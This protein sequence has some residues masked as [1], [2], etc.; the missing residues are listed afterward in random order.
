MNVPQSP[1]RKKLRTGLKSFIKNESRT[2]LSGRLVR[3]AILVPLPYGLCATGRDNRAQVGKSALKGG[4]A[5][6]VIAVQVR[7]DQ[8]V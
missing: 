3:Q 8:R 7:I 6:T 4:I 5:T 1:T 2:G